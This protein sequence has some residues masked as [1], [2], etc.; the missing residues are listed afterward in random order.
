MY[1]LT[2]DIDQTFLKYHGTVGCGDT[3]F[4]PSAQS[5]PNW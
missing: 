3:S 4:N 1:M 2:P 5:H